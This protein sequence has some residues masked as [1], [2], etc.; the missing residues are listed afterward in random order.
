M[1]CFFVAIGMNYMM[2][3]GSRE[4]VPEIIARFPGFSVKYPKYPFITKGRVY[5]HKSGFYDAFFDPNKED[6]SSAL[7]NGLDHV[8]RVLRR[9]HT[10]A[11]ISRRPGLFH[12]MDFFLA[13]VWGDNGDKMIDFFKYSGLNGEWPGNPEM[14]SFVFRNGVYQPEERGVTCGDGLIILGTEERHRRTTSDLSEYL[15]SPP[16]LEGFI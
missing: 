5:F 13:G 2:A 6:A 15:G 10:Q 9:D 12:D 7:D 14:T 16:N 4:G 3:D 1:I 8:E 11:Q